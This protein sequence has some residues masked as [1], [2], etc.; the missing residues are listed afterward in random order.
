M[1]RIHN[2]RQVRLC[3]QYRDGAEIQ[4]ISCGGLKGADSSFAEHHI[5]IAF[6]NDVLRGVESFINGGAEP[7][8]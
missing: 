4:G 8:L 7:A 2:H 5:G 1:G 6:R 3:A